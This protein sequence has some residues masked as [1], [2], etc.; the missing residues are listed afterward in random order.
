MGLLIFLRR[1]LVR[2]LDARL[3]PAFY[4]T[5]AAEPVVIHDVGAA[6]IVYAPFP[7]SVTTW[8]PVI[9]F[10]PHAKS[11]KGVVGG[12]TIVDDAVAETG[13]ATD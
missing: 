6:G 3:A 9:G 7:E 5:F 1:R 4:D 11:Y 8:A 2:D 10:E 12:Q 13:R